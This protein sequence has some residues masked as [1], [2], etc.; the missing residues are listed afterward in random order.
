[1]SGRNWTQ[2]YKIQKDSIIEKGDVVYWG[3]DENGF[4]EDPQK[5]YEA[6]LK[7]I[8]MKR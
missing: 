6:R 3:Q 4:P 1:M 2:F 8:I 5:E 7:E